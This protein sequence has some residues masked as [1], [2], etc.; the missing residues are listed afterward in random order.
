MS[1]VAPPVLPSNPC[2]AGR[3]PS[4]PS[5]ISCVAGISSSQSK[6][7]WYLLLAHQQESFHPFPS[8]SVSPASSKL[9]RESSASLLHLVFQLPKLQQ[10]EPQSHVVLPLTKAA[11]VPPFSKAAWFSL[12]WL[13]QLGL[14][15]STNLALQ[16]HFS[17][18][19]QLAIP[20]SIPC[21]FQLFLAAI[22]SPGRRG[23]MA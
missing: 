7:A 4:V 22:V 9:L 18:L 1:Q 13:P 17:L 11:W 19:S 15:P 10:R 14:N 3:P 6:P 16:S 12:A 5:T 8:C 23:P 21:F 2:S 20:A